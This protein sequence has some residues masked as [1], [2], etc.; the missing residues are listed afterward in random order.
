M[1]K[2]FP[3]L[4]DPIS[5]GKV[6]IRNRIAMAPM[7]V[8]GLTT[9]DGN[10]G[11]RAIDYYIER[12]RGSVGL[13]IT[14]VF[15]VENTIESLVGNMH[16]INKSSVAPF[17][18]LCEAAH[19]LG[20]KVFVQLTAGFGR[21]A[22]HRI[23]NTIPV[24]ASAIPHLHKTEE[25]CRPLE[26]IEIEHIVD[27]FGKAAEILMRAGVDGIEL[28][29]HE[30]YLLDQ[31]TT[32]IWNRRTDRYG[33][34]LK[35]RLTFPI[36]ILREIKKT[37]G[38]NFPVQYRF[39]LKHYIKGLNSGALPGEQFSEAGRD[40]AEGIEMAKLLEKAG[41]DALHIDAGCYDSWYWAHPPIYQ[42]HGCMVNMAAEVK[43]VVR[44][45]VIA[46]G[47]LE[48]PELAEKVI[49]DGN[50]DLIAIGRGLLSDPYWPVKVAEGQI[51][52]IRPCIGCHDG[53]IG[54]FMRGKPLSCAVNPACGR[55][56]LYQINYT[57]RKKQVLII[58]GGMAGMEAAR[59]A[60]ERGNEVTIIEK[61]NSLGGHLIEASVPDFKRD[62][63]TLLN[64]YRLQLKKLG[65]N[66]KLGIIAT[67]DSIAAEIPDS[68]IIATGSQ[69]VI[70]EIPG[71]KNIKVTTCKEALMDSPK[72]GGPV[73]VL[74]GGIT[75]CETSLW[76]AKRGKKV[77]IIEILPELMT[78]GIPVPAM[79]RQMLLDLLAF[80]KVNILTDTC[81]QNINDGKIS[82]IKNN[83]ID[84]LN[85]ESL[86]LACGLKPEDTL[87]KAIANQYAHVYAIGDCQLPRN[88]MAA[89][90]DGYEVGRSI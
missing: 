62:L 47:R 64:W 74:G 88:I 34:D 9:P 53:C 6:T 51:A 42:E 32:A 69:P 44:I 2:F 14:S 55:E 35:S 77:S 26:I 21:V 43:K 27:A 13:I 4:F 80:Y 58:G 75:G 40:I 49:A 73:T 39:G 12:A 57:T 19:A 79:N 90:W 86:V 25:M 78:A 68:I 61:E 82:I 63:R 28:H 24:S 29:G 20:T 8:L 65:V 18:E 45:P 59:V 5:I 10:P 76:L 83:K 37:A 89:I 38:D 15:K 85:T 66:I 41:F 1:S 31:F 23:I 7:G 70:P 72:M 54:R 17:G 33:G 56:R 84:T 3:R 87:Y 36:E 71:I 48:I 46:V 60:A 11:Q 22:P 16:M 50:A 81:V 67:A 30:G 52:D